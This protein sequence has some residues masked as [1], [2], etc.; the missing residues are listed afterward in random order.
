MTA[1]PSASADVLV[2]GGG[3]AG[4]A[5]SAQLAQ[6]GHRVILVERDVLPRPDRFGALLTPRTLTALQQLELNDLESFHRVRHVRLTHSGRSTST[7]WPSHPTL[8]AYAAVVARDVFDHRLMQTAVAAGVT[9]FAGHEATDPI[10]ERGFARG[11]TVTAPD[12]TTFEARADYTIVADGANS[13]FGRA[14]G[15]SRRPTWPYALAHRA[16][17]RS[18]LHD[19][20]EIE[21]LIDLRD[22]SDTPIA[23]YGWMLPSGDGNVTVGVM[24]MSTSASFQVVNPAHLL[25]RIVADHGARW[26]LDAEPIAPGIGGR[27]PL[28]LSVGPSAGPTYLLIGDAVGAGNPLSGAGIEGALETGALAA[29]VV[30]EALASGSAA[31]LQHYTSLLT[32][33]YGSYY[34][35]GR[36]ANRVLGQPAMSR[37]INRLVARRRRAADTFLRLATNELRPGR[38][39]IAEIAF[40]VGHTITVLGPDA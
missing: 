14:L 29:G 8:P 15:T 32:Q 35:V 1:H 17:Y 21:L 13:R 37:R 26:H 2:I 27:V 20:S 16:T 33:Q 3:P 12:G 6:R 19:A 36:L 7:T 5:A 39:G 40:R 4:S 18:P 34:K 10:I 23:G 22:R 28:G 25:E 11:A 38:V 31:A 9:M 30:D 24:L